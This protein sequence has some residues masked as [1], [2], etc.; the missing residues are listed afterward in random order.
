MEKGDIYMNFNLFLGS[1]NDAKIWNDSKLKMALD[2]GSLNLP[3][4]EGSIDFHFIGDDIFGMTKSLM[5]PFTRH[6]GMSFLH[7]IFNYR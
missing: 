3:Q 4:S 1:E 7:K 6:D 5:K 2:N